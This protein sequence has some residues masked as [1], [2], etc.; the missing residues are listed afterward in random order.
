MT[1]QGKQAIAKF[2]TDSGLTS[3]LVGAIRDN[4]IDRV[5]IDS[6]MLLEHFLA[7]DTAETTTFLSELKQLDAT[8][9][10]I[11][12]M[13]DPASYADEHYLAHGVIFFHNF[14]QDGGMTRGVQVIKM[15]GTAIEPDIHHIEFGPEGITVGPERRET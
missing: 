9:V 5:V 14:M 1:E 8:V 4:D 2:G 6:T 15:R 7:G 3:R 12:E 13:T 10:L 11:S